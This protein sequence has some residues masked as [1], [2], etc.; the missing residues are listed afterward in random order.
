[1]WRDEASLLDMLNTCRALARVGSAHLWESF[2]SDEDLRRLTERYF[3]ILG[4]AASRISP[5]FQSAYTEIPWSA[6]IG[7]RNII[8]YQYHKIDYLKIWELM[9]VAVP[10]FLILLESIAPPKN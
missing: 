7:L 4:E 6:W 3:E 9:T 10:D 8:A 1:M 5:E 2:Q